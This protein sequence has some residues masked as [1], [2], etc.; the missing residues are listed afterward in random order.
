MNRI[1]ISLVYYDGFLKKKTQSPGTVTAVDL[2]PTWPGNE[3]SP[4]LF[5]PK[6][7]S[8]PTALHAIRNYPFKHST[9]S[10]HL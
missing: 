10:H 5:L 9:F 2:Q 6:C 1:K 7:S 3:T 8:Q 4:T